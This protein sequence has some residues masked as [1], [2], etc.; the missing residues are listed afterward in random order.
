MNLLLLSKSKQEFKVASM[1]VT[2]LALSPSAQIEG[3]PLNPLALRTLCPVP[4][5]YSPPLKLPFC[6]G[7]RAEE[8]GR[9][10]WHA[11]LKGDLHR[12]VQT[13]KSWVAA[14]DERAMDDAVPQGK[15]AFP[16]SKESPCSLCLRADCG[17]RCDESDWDGRV[18]NCWFQRHSRCNFTP[19]PV[20]R[21]LRWQA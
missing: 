2:Y 15:D 11:A 1:S 12:F 3:C 8:V 16:G 17:A 13:R 10:P 6:A 7:V 21:L 14:R 18:Y 4:L 19:S 5:P 20:D 9:E